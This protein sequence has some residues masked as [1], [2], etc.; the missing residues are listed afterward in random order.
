MVEDDS[1]VEFSQVRGVGDDID[2]DEEMITTPKSKGAAEILL[3]QGSYIRR[4]AAVN[5]ESRLSTYTYS[6]QDVLKGVLS[7]EESSRKRGGALSPNLMP[8]VLVSPNRFEN[9][10]ESNEKVRSAHG[11]YRS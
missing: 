11:Y 5:A 10:V 9:E 3:S 8:Q 7:K 4:Q 1:D 6:G 2:I